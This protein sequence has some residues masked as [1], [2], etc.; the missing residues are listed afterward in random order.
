MYHILFTYIMYDPHNL[1][2]CTM[3]VSDIIY[4]R[5]LLTLCM[6]KFSRCYDIVFH[7][8]FFLFTIFW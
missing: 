3:Y 6:Y 2:L 8:F 7:G 5:V 1:E 4:L